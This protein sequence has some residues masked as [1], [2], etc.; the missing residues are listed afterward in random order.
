MHGGDIYQNKVKYD[1]SVN[2]NPKGI[3]RRVKS[4]LKK[5]VKN[6]VHY[7]DMNC[8]RLK[9][10]LAEKLSVEENCLNFGNGASELIC[11]FVRAAKTKSALLLAPSFSGYVS[12]MRSAGAKINYFYLK[13]ENG[14]A[15][16]K[17]EAEALKSAIL[18][19]KYDTVII[20]NPNN[21]NGRLVP[22]VLIK[23]IADACGSSDA[24]LLIDECFME[25]TGKAADFSFLPFLNNHKYQKVA[26]LRAFTKTFAVPGIRLGY[27][28]SSEETARKIK[29]QLPE[30]N[31]SVLA[32]EAGA[33]CLGEEK[34]LAKSLKIISRERKYL[35]EKLSSLGF[36]VFPSGANYILFKDFRQ[37]DLKSFL[38]SRKILIRGCSDY[39]G[40]G[41]GFYRIAVR[42][43]RENRRLV[44]FLSKYAAAFASGA[45]RHSGESL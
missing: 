27:C 24:N 9:K 17:T 37:A 30:W 36:K 18:S 40:L 16:D 14:F 8:A 32:E 13:E 12:A 1:F 5:S 22:R 23:E 44:Y 25:L 3:P 15:L 33:A 7:P 28:V 20:T 38:L 2:V 29:V 19:K 41:E 6:A 35:S 31:V 39:E 42:T 10:M 11:A 21:P 34:Y 4:A 43:R 26:V 45:S